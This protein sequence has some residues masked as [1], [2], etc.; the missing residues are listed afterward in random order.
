MDV[1]LHCGRFG[2]HAIASR[3]ANAKCFHREFLGGSACRRVALLADAWLC[4]VERDDIAEP[5][6]GFND[7]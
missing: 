7:G 1:V 2:L 5:H 6:R 4:S 3:L